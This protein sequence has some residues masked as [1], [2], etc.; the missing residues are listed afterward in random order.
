VIQ[1]QAIAER[2]TRRLRAVLFVDVVDSVR[3]IQQD[4]ERTVARWREF[5]ATVTRDDLP[6]AG[7]EW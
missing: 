3:L 2:L 7:G 5:I 6:G 4:A 1:E